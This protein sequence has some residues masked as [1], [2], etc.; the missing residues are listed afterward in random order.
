MKILLKEFRKKL[1]NL[2]V[3]SANADQIYQLNF[4]F[5]PLVIPDRK[6]RI[7]EREEM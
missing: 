1:L 5:F 3:N 7:A 2:A 4:Q 6:A